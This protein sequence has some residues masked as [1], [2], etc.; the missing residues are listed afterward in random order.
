AF[1]L[2]GLRV[3]IVDDNETNR[4]IL[5]GWAS[6]WGMIPTSAA[7]VPAAISALWRGFATKEPFALGLVDKRMPGAG[8]LE[9]AKSISQTAELDGC[10]V[11]LL[12]SDDRPGNTAQYRGLRLSAVLMKPV[13]QE[14][15]LDHV[16]RVL[17]HGITGAA[18]DPARGR[19]T[20]AAGE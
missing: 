13:Q 6:S 20:A 19:A 4:V 3:L 7:G 1:D 11:I 9:L 17:S 18:F 2:H 8:G 15:L 14:E 10:R 5:Q 12:T 16:Y